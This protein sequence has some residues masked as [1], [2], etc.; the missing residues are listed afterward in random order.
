M[1][2]EPNFRFENIYRTMSSIENNVND[3][4]KEN[5]VNEIE[6]VGEANSSLSAEREQS[7]KAFDKVLNTLQLK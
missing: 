2:A 6:N 4:Q 5:K 1:F 3:C 7:L